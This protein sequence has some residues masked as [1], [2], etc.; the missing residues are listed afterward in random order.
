M[1]RKRTVTTDQIQHRRAK[2]SEMVV[3]G[4]TEAQMMNE[5]SV[6]RATVATD[7][8]AIR[9]AWQ[10]SQ[11]MNFDESRRL[12]A[13][14]IDR[15][16]AEAFGAWEK[17]KAGGLRNPNG[18]PRFLEL[19]LKAV[20]RRC[21]LWGL[22]APQRIET[23]STVRTMSVDPIRKLLNDP[24]AREQLLALTGRLI[25]LPSESGGVSNGHEP[26][27]L[28]H[29]LALEPVESSI[30]PALPRD[31]HSPDS[32]DA[33]SARQ[34]RA[35]QQVPTGVVPGDESGQSSN[36]DELRS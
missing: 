25:D 27:A 15:I 17:S 1:P 21:R 29:G 4:L 33:T 16:M 11:Q 30:G 23:D 20:D 19:A 2:V 34:E 6:S 22:D 3:R 28:A 31:Q 8:R 10:Q 9:D 26:R 5:L 13:E 32:L 36:S 7:K 18:D 14:R 24:V 12:E 35:M